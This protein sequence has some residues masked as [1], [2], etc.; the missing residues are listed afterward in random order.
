MKKITLKN[1]VVVK[2]IIGGSDKLSSYIRNEILQHVLGFPIEYTDVLNGEIVP[3]S[4]RDKKVIL[5]IL[6]KDTNKRVFN[7]EMQNFR[8]I[9]Y[10]TITFPSI[11]PKANC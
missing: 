8:Y 4:F 11:F 3:D 1:D 6:V 7:I 2:F 5:D 9:K 10:R